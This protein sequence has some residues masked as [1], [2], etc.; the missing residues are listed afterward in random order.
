MD[1]FAPLRPVTTSLRRQHPQ[2]PIRSYLDL[3]V[4]WKIKEE[5]WTVTCVSSLLACQMLEYMREIIGLKEMVV[6]A[7][8]KVTA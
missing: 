1:I 7:L 8:L 4:I 2:H 5:A 3:N 6:E